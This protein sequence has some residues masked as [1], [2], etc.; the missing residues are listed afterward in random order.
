MGASELQVVK[1]YLIDDLHRVSF[2]P[3][4]IFVFSDFIEAQWYI[5]FPIIP[6]TYRDVANIVA[7]FL[8]FVNSFGFANGSF[9]FDVLK[10]PFNFPEYR[11]LSLLGITAKSRIVDNLTEIFS[12]PLILG[13]LGGT[14]P[15]VV[16]FCDDPPSSDD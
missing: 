6:E 10:T 7:N 9:N 8:R 14:N 13:E 16:H 15:P 4:E 5:E 2:P 1:G 11:M 3:H 12:Q